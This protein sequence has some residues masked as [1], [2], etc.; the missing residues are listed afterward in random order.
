MNIDIL[1]DNPNYKDKVEKISSELNANILTKSPVNKA[2]FLYREN[3]LNFFSNS[4]HSKPLHIDFLKGSMGWRLKRSD[5]ETLLKKALGKNSISLNI[6]DGTAG[7]LSDALIFLALGHKVIAC[8]QSMVLFLLVRDAV[9]RSKEE[10]PFLKNLKLFH[11]NSLKCY[12]DQKDIDV[13]YLDPMYPEPKKNILRSGNIALIKKIL[14]IEK[15]QDVGD[16]IFYKFQEYEFKKIILKRPIKANL[17]D[18]QLNYQIKG[19]STRFDIY[20]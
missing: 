12:Q 4:I 2:F 8:E 9:E 10:L 20:I 13:I 11:G 14:E 1:V 6:F 17:L 16:E 15:I 3:G 5:H 7:L 18:E 19:K